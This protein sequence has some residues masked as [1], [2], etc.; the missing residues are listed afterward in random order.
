MKPDEKIFN[1]NKK[2]LYI[3][4]IWC[5]YIKNVQNLEKYSIFFIKLK[6]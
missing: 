4:I 2:R 3:A 6:I 1:M 5:D